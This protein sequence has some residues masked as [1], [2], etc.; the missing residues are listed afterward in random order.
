V[1]KMKDDRFDAILVGGPGDGKVY[2]FSNTEEVDATNEEKPAT[3]EC[4]TIGHY[5]ARRKDG[6]L[7]KDSEGR[8][9][10]DFQAVATQN[11]SGNHYI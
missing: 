7:V 9:V 3:H 8:V 4:L 1:K 11:I 2:R 10:Y 6:Q 5:K